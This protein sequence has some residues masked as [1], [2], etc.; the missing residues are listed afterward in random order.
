MSLPS[1]RASST[2]SPY[3]V[4]A[5]CRSAS[6]AIPPRRIALVHTVRAVGPVTAALT[7]L[8]LAI[9][10]GY[11]DRWV[12]W[13]MARP[14][15]ATS[16]WWRVGLASRR[17][18]RRST[19]CSPTASA[20]ARSSCSTARAARATSCSAD[21]L[22]SWR[23]RLDIDIKVTVDSADSDWLGH[24]GVVTTL[25][26]RAEFDPL[27]A[28][29]LVCG[30]E[31]MMRFAIAALR[32]A[33]IGGRCDLPVDG[34]QHEVRDRTLRPLPVRPTLFVC[35]DGPVFTVRSGSSRC[36]DE[37]A[38]MMAQKRKPQA[39][40]LEVRLLRRLPAKPARLRGRAARARRARSRS[41]TSPRPPAARSRVPTIVSLVEGSI[42]TPHDAERI[43][44]VRRAAPA[45][46]SRSAPARPPAESRRCATSPTSRSSRGRRL[47]PPEYIYTLATS[48]P[49]ADHVPVDFELRGCP[50]N[51]RQ[52]LEVIA[53]AS[54]PDAARATPPHSVC[55]ECKR[56]RHRVR[57]G[58]ARHPLPRPGHPR[59]LRRDLPGVRSRLLRL[60][61]TDG[62][63][64]HRLAQPPGSRHARQDRACARAST[65]PSTPMRRAFRKES[66]RP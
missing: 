58:G 14:W 29:A 37:G 44:E 63:A 11:A 15:V 24:V 3:S 66:E 62:D 40:G 60:L 27:H 12:A 5:R 36:S 39:R 46:W 65:A 48:T 54:S 25:I 56:A 34:A 32:D 64:E 22:E 52:L 50:I 61:R 13:P 49:I 21:E 57:D 7:R 9:R 38:L 47:R 26:T 17:C 4:S 43:L 16:W 28:I 35:R 45:R 10:S 53:R 6:A 33:G 8:P 30:P 42:T 23:R 51:K 20:T 41:P 55:V 19:A 2:C 1:R 18:A 59:R 31:V